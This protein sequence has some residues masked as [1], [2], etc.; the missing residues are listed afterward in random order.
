MRYGYKI[1]YTEAKQLICHYCHKAKNNNELKYHIYIFIYNLVVL[2]IVTLSQTN[3]VSTFLSSVITITV[4]LVSFLPSLLSCWF[5]EALDDWDTADGDTDAVEDNDEY[6][7]CMTMMAMNRIRHTKEAHMIAW[8][9]TVCV[10]FEDFLSKLESSRRCKISL[11]ALSP[12]FISRLV[13]SCVTEMSPSMLDV[14]Q[15]LG[16]NLGFTWL[17]LDQWRSQSQSLIWL[18]WLRWPGEWCVNHASPFHS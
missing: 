11:M 12:S 16:T 3:S 10:A 18:R 15:W 2:Y 14:Y 6:F 8:W 9:R 13:G 17:Q 4:S 7:L 5:E 1:N